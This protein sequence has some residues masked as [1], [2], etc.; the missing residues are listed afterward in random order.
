MKILEPMKY[1]TPESR[2][3]NVEGKMFKHVVSSVPVFH[4]CTTTDMY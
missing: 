1:F 4:I 3:I 2:A